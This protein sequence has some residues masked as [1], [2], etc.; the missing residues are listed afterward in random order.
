MALQGPHQ[1]AQ[2]S[3][4]SGV[5]AA[6]TVALKLSVVRLAIFS[7]MVMNDL[8]QKRDLMAGNASEGISAEWIYGG[9]RRVPEAQLCA[10]VYR[11]F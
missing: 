8:V 9:F 4:S 3:T 1:G 11:G 5:V 6:A 10:G 7:D 2:K